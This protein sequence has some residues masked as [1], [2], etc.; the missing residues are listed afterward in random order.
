V[1]LLVLSHK[2]CWAS[3]ES[4]SGYA[5][6][7]GFPFQMR[8]LSELFDATTVLVPCVASERRDGAIPLTG[9]NLTIRPL[10]A[11]WGRGVWRKVL[12]PIWLTF[13]MAPIMAEV[14]RADA[15][16]TP[17]PGDVGT[18]GMLLGWSLRKPLYVRHCGNWLA[19]KTLA[20][21]FW[22]WFIETCAGGRY[23]MSATGGA[24]DTPSRRNAAVRW[25]FST[26]LTEQEL[27]TY[28][29]RLRLAP[30]G[31]RAKLVIACRQEKEK[32]TGV[33]IDSLPLILQHGSDVTLDVI[34]DGSALSEFKAR[35]AA[36]G[37]ADRIVFH[38]KVGHNAVINLLQ[39]A[40][41]FCYPTVASEG[42]PKVV[43]EAL[44]CGLPVITTKVSVLP[45]LI[46]TR[47]G[48][49]I[50]EANPTAVAEAVRACLS[51][52]AAYRVMSIHAAQ[53]ARQYS[54]ER[55]RATIGN[56]LRAAWGPLR[57]DA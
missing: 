2:P 5:T 51:D 38:G 12:F 48:Y 7:G 32:G 52:P 43:L 13:N 40:D 15:V 50:D 37:L 56:W 23:V 35:A 11:L 18:I 1:K 45:Q 20:E 17:I 31:R 53:A 25:I 24:A 3:L 29:S 49:L 27:N 19:P 39:S 57:A 28:G 6:D 21:R 46:G 10:R 22:R 36:L 16:H 55:W 30:V 47:C 33:V 4:P 54:L 26:S 14:S 44:A 8:E 34:G 42:F 9:R 41:L